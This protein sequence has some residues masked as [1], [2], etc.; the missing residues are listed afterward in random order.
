M[1][2][3]AFQVI[4]LT[5]VLFYL[6][7]SLNILYLLNLNQS[8]LHLPEKIVC[9]LKELKRRRSLEAC[10]R[11]FLLIRSR[12]EILCLKLFVKYVIPVI[13]GILFLGMFLEN[14]F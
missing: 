14:L 4:T 11:E 13:S 10:M 1:V 2:T 6:T 9:V 5:T 8:Q 12:G 3:L 7:I